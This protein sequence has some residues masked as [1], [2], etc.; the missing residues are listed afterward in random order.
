MSSGP[1]LR[2]ASGKILQLVQGAALFSVLTVAERSGLLKFMVK[3]GPLTAPQLAVKSGLQ[4]RYIVEVLSALTAA[5][6]VQF[7]ASRVTW[8]LPDSVRGEMKY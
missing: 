8:T 4:E 2:E 3:A 7:D 1:D 5:E 6:I